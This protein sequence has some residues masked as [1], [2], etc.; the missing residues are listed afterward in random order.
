MIALMQVFFLFN[1][2]LDTLFLREF[3]YK[4]TAAAL[5]DDATPKSLQHNTFREWSMNYATAAI[6]KMHIISYD[7]ISVFIMREE[8]PQ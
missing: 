7:S 8:G 1:K 4:Q 2:I 5:N 3:T 6:V